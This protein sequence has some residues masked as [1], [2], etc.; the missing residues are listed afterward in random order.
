MRNS[1]ENEVY[2]D[3]EAALI[4][5]IWSR[6]TAVAD[7]S[8]HPLAGPDFRT[9]MSIANIEGE[10]SAFMKCEVTIDSSIEEVAAYNF[11]YMSRKK[12]KVN[13]RKDML[14]R[15]ATSIN[16]HALDK[17]MLRDLGFG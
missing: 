2:D 15:D 10:S 8:F 16:N 9:K 7:D 14:L 1:Y 5:S 13:D 11:I 17:I 12:V 4:D 6:M 3:S